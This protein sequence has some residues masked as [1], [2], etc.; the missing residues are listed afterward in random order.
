MNKLFKTY[1]DLILNIKPEIDLQG[2]DIPGYKKKIYVC[3]DQDEN[4]K[5]LIKTKDDGKK[6][7]SKILSN[8]EIEINK[9][10][11]I[12]S[13]EEIIDDNFSLICFK[14]S[15]EDYDK[16]KLFCDILLS[17]IKTIEFPINSSVLKKDIDDLIEIFKPAKNLSKDYIQGLWAELFLIYKSKDTLKAIDDWH[18]NANDRYDFG[19]EK[20]FIEVKS[21]LSNE[22]KHSFSLGQAYPQSED[23]VI[24]SSFKLTENNNDGLSLGKLYEYILKKIDGNNRLEN[25]L[26]SL[27]YPVST[28]PSLDAINQSYDQKSAEKN[29]KFINLDNIPKLDESGLSLTGISNIKFTSN[30]DFSEEIDSDKI[31]TQAK[32][33]KNMII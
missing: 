27:I 26:F 6:Y 23:T 19:K 11:V 3:I 33:F 24:I 13:R 22:R 21:T 30:L 29:L 15:K 12:K 10:Y 20:Y 4:I 18:D 14:N 28:E 9:E 5:I 1:N 25:K 16:V 2:E 32:I 17:F 7:P 8:L 31:K